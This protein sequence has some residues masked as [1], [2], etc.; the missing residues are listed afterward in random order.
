VLEGIVADEVHHARLGWYYAM[1]RAPQ[2]TQA[3]RQRVANRVAEVVLDLDRKFAGMRLPEAIR[4]EVTRL[5]VI[6]AAEQRRIVVRTMNEEIIP[7]L[8][9]LGLGTSTVYGSTA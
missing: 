2:W 5:G 8:D 1:W 7:A 9:A 6:D 3:E 4:E